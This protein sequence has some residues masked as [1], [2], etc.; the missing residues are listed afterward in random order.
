MALNGG[1]SAAAARFFMEWI[2]MTLRSD[3]F[4]ASL[5]F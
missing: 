2:D 3:D 1:L 5:S 4:D